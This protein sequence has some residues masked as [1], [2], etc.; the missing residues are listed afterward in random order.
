MSSFV[1]GV[2]IGAGGIIFLGGA[3]LVWANN[4]IGPRF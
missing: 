1:L 2:L 4:N 3:L